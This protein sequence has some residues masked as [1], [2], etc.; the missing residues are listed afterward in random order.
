MTK[1]MKVMGGVLLAWTLILSAGFAFALKTVN[2]NHNAKLDEMRG[3]VTGLSSKVASSSKL[4]TLDLAKVARQWKGR[5]DELAMKAVETTV[6]FY[7][8]KGY[9]VVDRASVIGEVGKYE[10][11]VPTPEKMEKMLNQAK[12]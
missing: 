6:K 2:D 9:L 12:K 4:V 10:G 11:L 8:E 7:N 5:N 3:V 1:E